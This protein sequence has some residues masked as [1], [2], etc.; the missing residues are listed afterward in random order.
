MHTLSSAIPEGAKIILE[1]LSNSGYQAFVVGGCVRDALMMKT[2][3]DWDICTSASP[4]QVK[5]CIPAIIYDTGLRHGTV[6]VSM[7]D[8]MYEVTTFRIEG[9]YTDH[10]HPDSVAFTDDVITDLSRRDF[11]M[12][13]IAYNCDAGI[14]DPFGGIDDIRDRVISC[15]GNPD[16]RFHEDA[17]RIMRAIRFASVLGFSIA[18]ETADSIRRNVHLLNNIAAE[19][20]SG[21]L[22][23]TL[24][25]D[26][27]MDMMLSFPEVFCEII[28]ELRRCY[29]FNQNNRFHQYT[30]YDHIAHAI[31]N[32]RGD[33]I[34]VR[35][36]LFFHDIGKPLCYTEDHNGGHFYGHGEVSRSVTKIIM[37]RM[38]FDTKT[39]EE[40]CRLVQYHDS[41]I[42]PTEKTVRRWLNKVGEDTFRR[43]IHIRFADIEAH[44]P[45]T[46]HSRIEKTNQ[47]KEV[48]QNVI[49][50]NQCFSIKDME[51]DGNDLISI[52]YQQGK[53]IGDVLKNLLDRIIDEGLQNEHGILIAEAKRL[54]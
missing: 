29:G 20:I 46:Q 30:V 8:G 4:D 41:I 31:G 44:S 21:E 50:K 6:T 5:S 15:V 16:E 26:H 34:Y 47:V 49:K 23:Q 42:E 48:F 25:G 1:L 18:Q 40:V 13:A 33:D 3:H 36:A 24:S 45:D 22:V 10:R 27:A 7:K 54:L 39:R 53:H 38:R 12:N 32:Y 43:L 52:G 2:P 35:L 17:L 51:I 11:K 14:V 19:R 9:Q 37:E 28:P